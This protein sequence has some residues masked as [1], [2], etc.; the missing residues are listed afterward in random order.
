MPFSYVLYDRLDLSRTQQ[1]SHEEV[2]VGAVKL[3]V[4]GSWLR[5]LLPSAG[6]SV[7]AA[8]PLCRTP[9]RENLPVS[10]SPLLGGGNRYSERTPGKG[11]PRFLSHIHY[12]SF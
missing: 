6:E 12:K 7:A 4:M 10:V 2:T 11:I 3:K 9:G 5:F 8:H 1:E